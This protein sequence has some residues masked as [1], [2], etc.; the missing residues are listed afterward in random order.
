MGGFHGWFHYYLL[1]KLG[2]INYLGYWDLASFGDNMMVRGG[3]N[4]RN[5][6]VKDIFCYLCPPLVLQ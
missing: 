3:I 4:K 2:H 5:S 6:P 1:E